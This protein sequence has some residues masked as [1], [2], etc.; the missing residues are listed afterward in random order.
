[1][2]MRT[3]W[4]VIGYINYGQAMIDFLISAVGGLVVGFLAAWVVVLFRQ[5]LLRSSFNSLNAQNLL[6]LITP[7]VL[8]Y[9]AEELHVSGIIAV[10]CAGL[11]HNAEAQRSK[12]LNAPQVHMG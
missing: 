7:F 3:L 1:L 8:Y 5:V 2:D 11:V 6:Y 9:L 12:L 10:V 4:Y